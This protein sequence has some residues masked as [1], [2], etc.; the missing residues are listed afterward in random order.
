MR[1]K[2]GIWLC[3]AILA[4]LTLNALASENKDVPNLA[5]NQVLGIGE[6]SF[7]RM[8]QPIL[9]DYCVNCHEPGGKGYEKSGLDLTSYQGL[10]KGTVFGKVVIP[11]NSESSTFTKL[12]TGTNNGLKMPMG[13]N[14]TGTLDRQY[15]LLLKK[16]VKQGAKDN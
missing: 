10:M 16:W 8:V 13:L 3:G 5:A 6:V 1:M 14:D 15:I 2:I 9:H 12:L 11:G 7:K 4:S